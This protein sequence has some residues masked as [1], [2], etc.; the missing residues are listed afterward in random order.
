MLPSSP[1]K[2]SPILQLLKTATLGFSLSLIGTAYPIFTFIKENLFE[3]LE[4]VNPLPFFETTFKIIQM[5]PQNPEYQAI[6]FDDLKNVILPLIFHY[7]VLITLALIFWFLYEKIKKEVMSQFQILLSEIKD[8]P[9]FVSLKVLC[10]TLPL[11][12]FGI[13]L[14]SV[15]THALHEP[16]PPI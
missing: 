8:N 15:T 16:M 6:L 10:F 9:G 14:F 2:Q 3:I 12:I 7:S 1:Q 5:V 11:I 13:Q 4:K